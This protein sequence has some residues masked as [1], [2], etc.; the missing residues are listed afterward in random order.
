MDAGLPSATDASLATEGVINNA[1]W[2]TV[3]AA[4]DPFVDRPPAVDCPWGTYG[5]E[6]LGG[7]LAYFIR[8]DS[9]NYHVA[10]Q[11]S[12]VDIAEGDRLLLEALLFPLDGPEGASA[13]FAVRLGDSTIW[14]EHV[15]IPAQAMTVSEEWLAPEAYPKGTPVYVHV[16]N[17]GANEYAVLGL[18]RL[19]AP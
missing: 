10:T 2:R 17:H 5:D 8:T 9:C 6:P 13:H 19:A 12:R 18:V 3:D 15:Q 16:H 4:T 11:P 14:E 7:R 1:L